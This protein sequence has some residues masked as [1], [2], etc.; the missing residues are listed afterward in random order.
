M[1]TDTQLQEKYQMLL[2]HLDEKSARLFLA[3]EAK[4]MGRG[5]KVKVAKLAGVSRV[6]INKGIKELES[7]IKPTCAGKGQKTRNPGGGRKTQEKSQ[8][9]MVEALEGIVNPHTLG[10]PM[11]PLLWTSKSLRKIQ[12]ELKAQ[13]YNV[14]HVTIG[15][16]LKSKGYSLQGNKKTHEGGA[17]ADRNEQFEYINQAAL[18]FMKEGAPVISVD[19]KKKELIGNFKNSGAEWHKKGEA[20]NVKVYDFIDK[21][22]GKAVPYGVYDMAKNQGWVNVG[23]SKDTAEFAVNSIRTWWQQ[24]GK[25]QY[26]LAKKLLITADGGGS[27]SSRSRLWKKELQLFASETGLEI[28]V[29]HFPPGTSKWNKIEHRLFSFISKN[30][31]GKP[32]VSLEVIVNLIANTTTLK[33]LKVKALADKR[34]YEKGLK[35]TN[36][37]LNRIKLERDAF[38]GDWNYEIYP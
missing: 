25:E 35:V 34:Q 20:P 1:S 36:E 2:P 18:S 8:P 10:D 6:R 4:S 26:G 30:W 24:M 19:C 37:E 17:V 27:N 28:K 11:N 33:G 5:A 21:D 23:I 9:G 12:L 29:C 16:I 32:L 13:H 7:G 15:G 3:S 14:G 22:L 31:R 38:R